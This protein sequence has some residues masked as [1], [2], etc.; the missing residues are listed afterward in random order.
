[1]I[2][3][4][5]HKLEGVAATEFALIVPVLVLMLIGMMDFGLYINAQMKMQHYARSAAEYVAN[6]GELANIEA[7]LLPGGPNAPDTVNDFSNLAF[8]SNL[9]CECDGGVSVSC[10]GTCDADEYMRTFV[11][12]TVQMNYETL[13]PYPGLP[14]SINLAGSARRQI[15]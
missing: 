6:G 7:D 4:Y 2:R 9:E 14:D 3:E 13:F 11:D 15:Q 5:I 8:T 12:I 1:M 10:D